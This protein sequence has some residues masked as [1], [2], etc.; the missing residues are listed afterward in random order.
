MKFNI[1]NKRKDNNINYDDNPEIAHCVI[2][3]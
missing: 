3:F 1:R 2:C